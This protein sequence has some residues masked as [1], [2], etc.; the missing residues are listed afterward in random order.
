MN[1]LRSTLL[2]FVLLV[3]AIA[4]VIIPVSLCGGIPGNP[5]VYTIAAKEVLR[6][7]LWVVL[8]AFAC[9]DA[10]ALLLLCRR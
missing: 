7:G 2:S 10:V 3:N 6:S 8:V 5:A 4:V 1:T 9:V